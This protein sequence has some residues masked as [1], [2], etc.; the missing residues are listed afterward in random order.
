[1]SDELREIFDRLI[2]YPLRSQ[3]KINFDLKGKTFSLSV[4]IFASKIGLP[5]SVKQYVE[6]RKNRT[7]KPYDTSFL[8]E[9]KKVV[10]T[11]KIPFLAQTTLRQETEDFLKMARHLHHI[12][13]EIATEERFKDALYLD[14]EF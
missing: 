7:F 8:S 3:I 12:L 2:A 13:T 11:Q 5:D 6:S 4:P 9:D 14:S 10:L 1:M